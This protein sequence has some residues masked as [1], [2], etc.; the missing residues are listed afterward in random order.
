MELAT[1]YLS[2]LVIF[3]SITGCA[4]IDEDYCSAITTA[5][6]G[7][8]KFVK[9]KFDTIFSIKNEG[10]ISGDI[11]CYYR[12]S[13]SK[14]LVYIIHDTNNAVGNLNQ[15]FGLFM[16]LGYNVL[17]IDYANEGRKCSELHPKDFEKMV[18]HTLKYAKKYLAV[19]SE[20]VIYIQGNAINFT[21][22]MLG[23]KDIGS[24]II[25]NPVIHKRE[26]SLSRGDNRDDSIITASIL[27]GQNSIR[28]KQFDVEFTRSLFKSNDS[29]NINIIKS[30]GDF[31]IQYCSDFYRLISENLNREISTSLMNDSPRFKW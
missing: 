1:R 11:R 2:I 8:D 31:D 18:L 10:E 24:L 12:N 21:H 5:N 19:D 23:R 29:I 3:L 7:A 20:I 25:E 26:T 30:C 17:S 28:C 4:S 6:Y 27:R 9:S 14:N 16:M 13:N 22:F 15:H